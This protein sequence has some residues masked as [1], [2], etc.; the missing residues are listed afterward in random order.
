MLSEKSTPVIKATLPVV[1]EHLRPIS[2]RF[3]RN[4]FTAVPAL[5]P[6]VDEGEASTGLH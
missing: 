1:N 6:S 5:E 3:Y 4:L 2:E